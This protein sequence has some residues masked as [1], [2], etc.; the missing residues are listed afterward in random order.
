V[1]LSV[2]SCNCFHKGDADGGSSASTSR[3][4]TASRSGAVRP[5][6]RARRLRRRIRR[7]HQG[8]ALPHDRA[9]SARGPHQPAPSR[10]LRLRGQHRRRRRHPD[11][12][13]GQVPAPGVRPPRRR[14]AA[15]E[16]LRL[17]IRVPAARPR[18]A[19]RRARAAPLDRRRRGAAAPRLARGAHRRPSDRRQRP[20]G[21]AP[22]H[23]GAHRPWAHRARSRPLRAQALRDPHAV[24]EGGG[25][26]RHSGKQVR[27]HS[28]PQ[29]EHAHLQGHAQRRSD[30]DDVPRS[31]RS[32][33]RVGAG[34]RAPAVQ[35]QYLP[36][37]A[38]L[39]P[40]GTSPTTARSTR[41]AGT[42]TG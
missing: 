11:P 27:L 24:R 10:G 22:H 42:S 19:R 38:A 14:A 34:A 36:V 13:S 20:V 8:A 4:R 21:R 29:L 41:C 3:A 5:Q 25:G 17:R 15:R 31:D 18:A 26:A 1:S 7:G 40:T 23:A 37:V 30:R 6:P 9:P 39:T 12:D 32:R 16:G 35:H 33:F 28:E 2:V